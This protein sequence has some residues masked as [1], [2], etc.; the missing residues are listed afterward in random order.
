MAKVIID[1]SEYETDD[2]SDEAK[3][4]L[5]N[6]TYCDRKIAD[7][8]NETAVVQ[9]ARNAYARSLSQLLS[10]ENTEMVEAD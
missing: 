8:K 3:A 1:G 6:L 2:M 4:Q 9:T 5:Q 10:G 7:L